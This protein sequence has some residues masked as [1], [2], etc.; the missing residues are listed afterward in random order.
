LGFLAIIIVYT[1]YAAFFIFKTS[2]LFEG[3]RYFVLFDDAMISMRYARNL[4]GGV[5]PV[6]NPGERVEGYT[7]PLWVVYMSIFH[8]FPIPASKTSLFIQVS[9]AITVVISLLFV[10]KIAE[11]LTNNQLVPLLSVVLTAFYLPVNTWALEGME[12]GVLVMLLNIA[13]WGALR[14]FSENRFWIWMYVLLGISTLIRFD[15]IVSYLTILG[16]MVISDSPNRKSHLFV[17][18]GILFFFIFS[19]TIFRVAYFGEFL[20]NTYYLKMTGAPLFL[21][22]KRGAFVVLTFIWNSYWPLFVLPFLL[23]FYRRDKSVYFPRDAFFLHII[24]IC[25]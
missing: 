5:G 20:P 23:L 1:I 12:V 21:R 9:G 2:F 16:S 17:G 8:L 3:E 13:V 25:K 15:M 10:K 22:L 7:N 18:G 11:S 6:W 19:Q 24:L 4:A 14:T